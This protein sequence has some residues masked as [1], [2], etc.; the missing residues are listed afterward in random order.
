MTMVRETRIIFEVKDIA[1]IRLQ[2]NKCSGTVVVTLA[3][4]LIPERCP[5]CCTLWIIA[6]SSR[7]PRR[8]STIFELLKALR[9][10]T[11]DA[12]PPVTI[13]LEL[14][15]EADEPEKS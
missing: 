7:E 9:A 1:G 6:D 5:M 8:M 12:N 4:N 13:K 15:G 3:D 14:D 10:W 11:N 2:C